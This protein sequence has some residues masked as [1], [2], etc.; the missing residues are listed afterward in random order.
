[1]QAKHIPDSAFWYITVR[2]MGRTTPEKE[3]FVLFDSQQRPLGYVSGQEKGGRGQG[4]R[5]G[6]SFTVGRNLTELTG[7][8]HASK[9]ELQGLQ[10]YTNQPKNIPQ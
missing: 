4:V 2:L 6:R 8:Y 10:K 1:M 5:A 9:K 7:Q 3:A